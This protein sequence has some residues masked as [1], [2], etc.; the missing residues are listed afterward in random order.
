MNCLHLA[1]LQMQRLDFE[2][3]KQAL[4]QQQ[5][6]EQDLDQQH[7]KFQQDSGV[8]T[9]A[10]FS[11]FADSNAYNPS[12]MMHGGGQRMQQGIG[13]THDWESGA[14]NAPFEAGSTKGYSNDGNHDWNMV[15][16]YDFQAGV[17]Q[18][19]PGLLSPLDADSMFRPVEVG[20]IALSLSVCQGVSVDVRV[21]VFV[22]KSRLCA[23]LF[24]VEMRVECSAHTLQCNRIRSLLHARSGFTKG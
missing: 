1:M 11:R 9:Y 6:F 23:C 8:E 18:Q 4:E 10:G 14:S 5:A 19:S 13:L 7:R 20:A 2:K 16:N 21:Y 24:V 12:S 15:T 17:A 22:V 3:Q